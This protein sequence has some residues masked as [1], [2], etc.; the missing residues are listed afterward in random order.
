MSA[1]VIEEFARDLQAPAELSVADALALAIRLHRSGE[2]DDAEVLYERI[3]AAQPDQPDALHFLGM[4]ALYRNRPDAAL[5]LIRKSVA[6]DA[7]HPERHN[8]LGNVL[9]LAGR[10]EEAAQAYRNAISLGPAH[11]D[12]HTNLG[13]ILGA[14]RRYDEAEAAHKRSI[15]LAP[16][17]VQAHHN[18][19]NLYMRQGRTREAIESYS[20]ALSLVPQHASSRR[21]LACA[22]TTIGQVEIAARLYR[23]WLEQHP[24]DSEAQHLYAAC[25]GENVPERASDAY[26]ESTFDRFAAS[27]DAKLASLE[28]RGP[29]L[30]A[31]ALAKAVGLAGKNL[32]IVDG[33]CGTGLCGSLVT[34]YAGRLE[35]VDLSSRML[36]EARKRGV[37]DALTRAELTAFLSAHS[38]DFDVIVSADTLVYFGPLHAV[39]QAAAQA[40]RTGGLLIFT[41]ETAQ[42][43]ADS[44]YR[45]QPHGRYSHS[46]GYVERTLTDC[47][48]AVAASEEAVLRM[49]FRAPAHGLVV[50]ARK[51]TTERR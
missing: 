23:E 46:R 7:R 20:K 40:L 5:E 15:E 16:D 19:G 33:G 12:A 22:Y 28:Y 37:Y 31:D 43:G 36:E 26:V 48:L 39:F 18:C 49:E 41:V 25:S 38:E 44:G 9:L 47:G 17:Q 45:I 24:E 51:D 8:N 30:I 21:S 11:A 10:S 1:H 27:F 42:Q 14:Q 4:L 13:V 34:A 35:G 32:S 6:L 29:Q 3:L 2:V 50:T